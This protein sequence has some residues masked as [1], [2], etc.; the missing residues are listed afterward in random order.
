MQTLF[1]CDTRPNVCIDS[2]Q[3]FDA[4]VAA[5][6]H[7]VA[8]FGAASEAFSQKNIN[9]SIEESLERFRPVCNK[10]HDLG[11]RVRGCV[12]LSCRV[13]I[14]TCAELMDD[15]CICASY[16]SCVLGCPYQ[17]P[18]SPE[19]VAS[20]AKKMYDMGCYEIS[21]GDTIGVGN[22]GTL[23]VFSP[24]SA[25]MHTDS[26]LPCFRLYVV[27][28]SAASTLDMLRATKE[29]VP[30][31]RLAV[32]FHDTYGQA[33]S[34]I[35]IALQVRLFLPQRIHSV[36]MGTLDSYPVDRSFECHSL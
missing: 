3:G 10:A 17:G 2:M 8:I 20:V 11:I 33:L 23:A 18:V 24:L 28:V 5:G 22:P 34:N 21:L 25:S 36:W 14:S 16:V 12:L 13:F 4:A 1:G 27:S 9:C 19:I 15:A 32:H 31:E 30:V 35:L 29:V 6:A 7:E 26:S